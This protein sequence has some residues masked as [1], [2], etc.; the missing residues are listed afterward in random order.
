MGSSSSTLVLN[1]WKSNI[2]VKFHEFFYE[3]VLTCFVKRQNELFS[4]LS[5]LLLIAYVIKS[6]AGTST[7]RK[8]CYSWT[9]WST[10][11]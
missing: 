9:G 5:C 3:D 11:K 8:A 1:M 2:V 10:L 6:G 7:P 4:G